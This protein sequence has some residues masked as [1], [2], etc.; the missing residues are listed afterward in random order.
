M[1]R[2]KLFILVFPF[3]ALQAA[4]QVN[5]KIDRNVF[6]SSCGKSFPDRLFKG[7]SKRTFEDIFN[8]WESTKYTDKR[9]LAYILATAYRESAGTM[10]PVRE[11]LCSTNE[12]SIAAVTA[13]FKKKKRRESDNYAIPVNGNS[14]FGRGLV[15]ITHKQNYA[16]IGQALGWGDELVSNPDLALDRDKAVVILVEGAVQGMFSKDRKTGKWRKLSTYLTDQNTDWLGARAIINPGSTRA[17]IPAQ[18]A[19]QFNACLHTI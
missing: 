18:H 2:L 3:I 15:Q 4:A 16:R 10:L 14:Y 6:Y 1:R 19:K 12:C 8:Y 17:H 11:A 13:Y 7:E 9:W 5:N